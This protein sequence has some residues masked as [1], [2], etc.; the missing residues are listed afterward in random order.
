MEKTSEFLPHDLLIQVPLR[1]P[2]KS[3]LRFRCVS[4]SWFSLISDPQFAKSHFELTAKHIQ[5]LM[6]IVSDSCQVLTPSIDINAPSL[7][8]NPTPP[9]TKLIHLL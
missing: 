1:L 9:L 7:H 2:A 8:A 3:L 5:K 4:K 6:I